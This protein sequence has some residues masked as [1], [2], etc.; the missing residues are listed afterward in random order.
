MKVVAEYDYYTL[1][2]ARKILEEEEKHRKLVEK[3]WRDRRREAAKRKFRMKCVELFKDVAV[4]LVAIVP[5]V[6][7]FLHWLFIGY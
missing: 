6:L 3:F 5:M 7:M 1:D 2:Q 4:A